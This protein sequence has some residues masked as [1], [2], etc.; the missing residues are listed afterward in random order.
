[1]VEHQAFSKQFAECKRGDKADGLMSDHLLDGHSSVSPEDHDTYIA[2]IALHPF[3]KCTW[4]VFDIFN[5]L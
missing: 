1:M 3:F 5:M 2:Y 4:T